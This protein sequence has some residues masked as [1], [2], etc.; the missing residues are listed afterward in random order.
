MTFSPQFFQETV[1]V[2]CFN[3]SRR[4]Q[5][6]TRNKVEGGHRSV[7]RRGGFVNARLLCSTQ[8]EQSFRSFGPDNDGESHFNSRQQINLN[9]RS[10]K[11]P[12][13]ICFDTAGVSSGYFSNIN[14]SLFKH[15]SFRFL[16]L[17]W[18][19]RLIVLLL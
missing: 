11:T 3:A 8:I 17:E 2:L 9:D 18:N 16:E 7:S 12:V 10:T 13:L 6:W 4:W 19:I 14:I 5:Q 1:K 15:A